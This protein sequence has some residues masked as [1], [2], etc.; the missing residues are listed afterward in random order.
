MEHDLLKKKILCVCLCTPECMYVHLAIWVLVETRKGSPLNR[1]RE[2]YPKGVLETK[3]GS[4]GRSASVLK[5]NVS[6]L[7]NFGDHLQAT[8]NSSKMLGKVNL[9]ALDAIHTNKRLSS[10]HVWPCKDSG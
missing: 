6:A 4:S 7:V 1:A 10:F 8:R 9:F 2:S 5:L 3:P